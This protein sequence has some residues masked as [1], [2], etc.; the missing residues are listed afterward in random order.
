MKPLISLAALWIRKLRLQRWHRAV[1]N[2]L[3]LHRRG[4]VRNDGL[5]L[6]D[7]RERID[8][9][10]RARASHPWDKCLPGLPEAEAFMDQALSDTEAALHRLFQVFP[11][12]DAIEFRV[13]DLKSDRVIIE[14]N[15]SRSDLHDSVPNGSRSVRMRLKQLGVRDYLST[16]V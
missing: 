6:I 5:N 8:I 7:V 14:G 13:L 15:V 1:V 9:C 4:E 2:S 3:A 16:A 12:T 11:A 10:W